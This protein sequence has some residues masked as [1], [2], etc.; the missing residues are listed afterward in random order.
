V[1]YWDS[2]AL[3]SLVIQQ[4]RTDFVRETLRKDGAIAS[5]WGSYLE[6]WGAI[7]RLRREGVIT[8]QQ[9]LDTRSHLR[10]MASQWFVLNDLAGIREHA[11]RLLAAH[12]LR[13]ADAIQLAA[14]CALARGQNGAIEFVCLDQRLAD[15]ATR[16]G[17]RVLR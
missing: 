6:C 15:A 11:E 13:T 3:V 9:A 2:S 12:A 17:F 5:W 4:P 8:E 10:V 14:A 7:C 16:E 1:K